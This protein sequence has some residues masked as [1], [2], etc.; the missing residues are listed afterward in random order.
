MHRSSLVFFCLKGYHTRTDESKS[1]RV[2][3]QHHRATL[4]FPKQSMYVGGG[5]SNLQSGKKCQRR[6]F[7]HRLIDYF[8]LFFL[9]VCARAEAAA[10][11]SAA[12]ER[13]FRRTP[14]A[15]VATRGVVCL[16]LLLD[17]AR[18]MRFN[19][20][21]LS[22]FDTPRRLNVQGYINTRFR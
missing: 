15:M 11:R 21:I 6:W 10:E 17:F 2:Q 12:E 19:F 13:G 16:V 20:A 18:V 4:R 7:Q 22:S 14:L 9:P 8:P 1:L 5:E 3:M